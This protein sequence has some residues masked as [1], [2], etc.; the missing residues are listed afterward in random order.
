MIYKILPLSSYYDKITSFI[1]LSMGVETGL[2]AKGLCEGLKKVIREYILFVNQLEAEYQ[3]D[4]LDIQKLWY[5]CQPSMKI[6]ENLQKLCYQASLIKGGCLINIIYAFLQGTTDAELKKL[7]TYLLS[8][9]IK[10]YFNMM[11]EW[12]CKGFLDDNFLEFMVVSNA[13]YT[14]EQLGDYYYDLYWEKKFILCKDNI[15]DFFANIADK[16]F[17]IGKILNILRMCHKVVN[18]PYEKQF[19]VLTGDSSSILD[20]DVLIN[21]QN[22]M[23]KI[24]E[25]ANIA[26]KDLLFKEENLLSIIKSMKRFYFMECGDFYTH[27]I[28]TCAEL[29]DLEKDQVMTDKFEN[30][31]DNTIR[32]TSAVLDVNRELFY[33]SF[34]KM[35]FKTEKLYLDMYTK[36]LE[37]NDIS[38]VIR[39][40]NSLDNDNSFFEF[41]DAKVS[42]SLVIE[43]KVKWPLNLIF[44]KQNLLKYQLIFRQLLFLKYQEKKL[45]ECWVIQQH[46]KG[47]DM[48]NHLRKSYLLRDQMI[49][50]NK[51]MTYY[52]FNEV[53]EPNYLNFTNNLLN[54][55]SIQD[56]INAHDSFLDLCLKECMLED[57]QVL[58]QINTI[59]KLSGTFSKNM[60]GFFELIAINEKFNV[61]YNNY[62]R[63]RGRVD[64]LAERRRELNEHLEMLVKDGIYENQLKNGISQ[65]EPNLKKLLDIINKT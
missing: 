42:E 36:V 41:G 27:F 64:Q 40:I 1:N 20:S 13:D 59:L 30:V 32:S 37:S 26:L 44:S 15:P 51:N 61:L 58:G 22:L 14:I 31:I 2:I 28:D 50:F 7:Y 38:T 56:I 3:T 17:F 6:L 5:L 12:V 35:I 45:S 34:S 8:E 47:T 48:V 49:T 46:Y 55:K 18:C 33:F 9:S 53:I 39:L 25:W 16:V 19:D 60:I 43:M 10:P 23:E 24:Y 54:A 52:F 65:F 29:L 11:K 62:I 63:C 4:N 21:F 57:A